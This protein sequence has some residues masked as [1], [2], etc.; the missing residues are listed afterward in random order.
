MGGMPAAIQSIL[1]LIPLFP[2]SR[3]PPAMR[4]GQ[5]LQ[6]I[7]EFSIDH[8]KWKTAEQT[9]PRTV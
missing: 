2:V 6:T 7:P 9:I 4:H 5:N 1:L 3:P 8:D